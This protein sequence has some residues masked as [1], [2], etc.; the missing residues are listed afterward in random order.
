MSTFEGPLLI[1]K[2]VNAI[3]HFTDWTV[4]H[5][6]VGAL[7][8]NGFMTFAMLYWLMPRLFSTPMSFKVID[9]YSL[10]VRYT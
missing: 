4:A 7:G 6:H 2:N 5:V 1:I 8:W 10:L 3:S 9:E